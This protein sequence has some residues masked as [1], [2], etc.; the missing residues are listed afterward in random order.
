MIA[1]KHD[2]LGSTLHAV[3]YRKDVTDDILV[4][5]LLNNRGTDVPSI[6]PVHGPYCRWADLR[7]SCLQMIN[8]H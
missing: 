6:S 4:K 8:N 5:I 1:G 3:F 2:I 7:E